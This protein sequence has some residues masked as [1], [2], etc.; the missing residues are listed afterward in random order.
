M[1]CAIW[2][3]NATCNK[4]AL[5]MGGVERIAGIN[6]ESIDAFGEP[7]FLIDGLEQNGTGIGGELPAV[8]VDGDGFD[9]CR[10]RCC[11]GGSR[12]CFGGTRCCAGG[13]FWSGYCQVGGGHD[14][15]CLVVG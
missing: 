7:D 2:G 12:C 8:K 4:V 11:V 6:D 14:T 3:S 5:L 10:T 15:L 1:R 9:S 13:G